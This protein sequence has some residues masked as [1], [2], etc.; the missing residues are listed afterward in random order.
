MP[1]S[2]RAR[3]PELAISLI[4]RYPGV[5]LKYL[6]SSDIDPVE[7]EAYNKA[8]SILEEQGAIVNKDVLFSSQKDQQTPELLD[9][10]GTFED[11]FHDDSDV[12]LLL[13]DIEFQEGIAEY[14]ENLAYNPSGVR[15]LRDLIKFITNCPAEEFPYRDIVRKEH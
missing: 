3:I 15:N 10:F 1:G 9:Q 13:L 7:L 6:S 8:I 2:V 14:F 12:E 11:F 4:L 5:P